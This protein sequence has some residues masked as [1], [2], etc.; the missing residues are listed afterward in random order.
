MNL[1]V[2]DDQTSVVN[3]LIK[4]VNWERAGIAQVFAAYNAFEAKDIFAQH[5]VDIMLCDIEMPA[6]NGL[7][8]YKWVKDAGYDVECVFLTAHA[9]F[10]YAREAI[11]LKSFDYIIQPAP[12]EEVE[13]VVARAV[14]RV[15]EKRNDQKIRSYGKYLLEKNILIQ[16]RMLGSWLTRSIDRE[17]YRDFSDLENI[18][19]LKQEGYLVFMQIMRQDASLGRWEP[20]LLQFVLWNVVS[21]WFAPYEQVVSICDL[22]R[23]EY[24]FVIYGKKG[25]HM[26]Y[27][28]VL[29]Q[30]ESCRGSFSEAL[31]CSVAFYAN[32]SVCLE[33]M[34]DL[35]ERMQEAGKENV[36]LQ[37]RVFDMCTLI[38]PEALS[39]GYVRMSMRR[40][41]DY[42]HQNLHAA[43][44][45]E[46]FR[47][48]DNAATQGRLT[49]GSLLDFHME[50]N[51]L[52][53]SVAE[54]NGAEDIHEWMR[55]EQ[56]EILYRKAQSSLD[57][58]KAFVEF[59][60]EHMGTREYDETEQKSQVERIESY[61]HDHI[62]SEI[63]REDI[64]EY[65]HLNVDY[66]G[67]LFKKNHGISL[68]EYI[69]EEKMRVAQNLLRTTMLPISFVAAKAGYAN[70]SHFS[71]IYKKTFGVSPT[72]ERK[73]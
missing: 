38:P 61:I 9:E 13:A 44:K 37:S 36:S 62:E 55:D 5:P 33:D 2:I 6:E 3:G 47:F 10:E 7:A 14:V 66:M 43:V 18:I 56:G 1:I 71:R 68:K 22:N 11:L 40:W 70:F 57:D 21:E 8:L 39:S 29:R 60:L 25:Y 59:A 4:G 58:M 28:G 41:E 51:K 67:R 27:A 73:R 24:A 48:L 16:N 65:V 20:S 64:A 45:E 49:A 32:P 69:I 17:S 30:L 52:I 54:Q 34:P 53:F 15:H 63:T 35:M 50:F 23:R 46:I 12:Y 31:K 42:I 26:D 72:E 19:S